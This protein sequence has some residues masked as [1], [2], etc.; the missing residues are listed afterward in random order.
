MN[1][2]RRLVG[3]HALQ[4]GLIRFISDH[5]SV[6]FVFSLARLGRQNMPG[7]CMLPDNFSRPGFLKPFSRTFVRLKFRHEIFRETRILP[8]R[9]EAALA[10]SD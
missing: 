6:Q 8:Q 9:A 1:S 5:T 3:D 7:K 4:L 10:R 2:I